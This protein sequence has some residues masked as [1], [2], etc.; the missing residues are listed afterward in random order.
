MARAD[1]MEEYGADVTLHGRTF[2]DEIAHAQLLV[3]DEY[4]NIA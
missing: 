3:D 4:S 1:A 2:R